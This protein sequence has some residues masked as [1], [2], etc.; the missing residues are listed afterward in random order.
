LDE[1]LDRTAEAL[2]LYRS[3]LA[4]D[5]G[6]AP[7]LEQLEAIACRAPRNPAALDILL[8]TYRKNGGKTKLAELL[9]LRATL[10]SSAKERKAVWLELAAVRS[11][12]G[13]V[14]LAFLALTQAFREDPE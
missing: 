14:E 12:L 4:E 13:E 11:E 5:A 3:L 6:F 1:R 2:D 8:E 9:S 7:V 10:S